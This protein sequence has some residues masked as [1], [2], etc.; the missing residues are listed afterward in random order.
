MPPNIHGGIG[1]EGEGENTRMEDM[2]G[3]DVMDIGEETDDE[4]THYIRL[5]IIM[6]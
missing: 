6:L 5:Y 4:T 3:V 2:N 1:K